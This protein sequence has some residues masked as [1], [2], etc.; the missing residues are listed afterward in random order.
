MTTHVTSAGK[1][2]TRTVVYGLV[3]AL[4]YAL[5]Y[6]FEH[7]FLDLASRGGWYFLV[8]VGIAFLFSFVHGAFTARFWDVLGVKAKR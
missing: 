4:L 7:A 8:P 6:L 3:A 2:I 5:L 1:Q